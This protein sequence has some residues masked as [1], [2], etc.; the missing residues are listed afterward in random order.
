M[1]L[2]KAV[3]PSYKDFIDKIH[4][5]EIPYGKLN[6]IMP[7]Y[8][9]DEANMNHIASHL[10]RRGRGNNKGDLVCIN[11]WHIIFTTQQVNVD[12]NRCAYG[13]RETCPHGNC[14]WTWPS[15]QPKVCLNRGSNLANCTCNPRCTHIVDF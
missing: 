2:S 13:S 1:L 10:C 6:P 12:Q 14:I 9:G 5:V 11:P 3:F 4:D 15:G 7:Y 8:A